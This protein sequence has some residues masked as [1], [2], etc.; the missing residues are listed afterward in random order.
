MTVLR[1]L[2]VATFLISNAALAS[3]ACD[4]AALKENQEDKD[5]CIA[6]MRAKLPPTEMDAASNDAWFKMLRLNMCALAREA[7]P[8]EELN[9][10]KRESCGPVRMSQP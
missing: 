9:K 5:A 4:R 3:P 1:Y 10:I 6:E 7:G 8:S 2:L